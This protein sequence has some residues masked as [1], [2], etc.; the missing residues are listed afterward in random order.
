[1]ALC[2]S[3]LLILASVHT[4]YAAYWTSEPH[5]TDNF[6]GIAYG[7]GKF[8]KV[9]DS[10]IIEYSSDG[11]SWTSSSTTNTRNLLGVAHGNTSAGSYKFLVVGSGG[12]LQ[13]SVDGTG[14]WSTFNPNS[15]NYNAAVYGASEG[16]SK[17]LAVGDGGQIRA[18]TGA[19]GGSWSNK[20][21]SGV[22]ANVYGVATGPITEAGVTR[23]GFV[24][25]GASGLIMTN[26]DAQTA[27]AAWVNRTPVGVSV[28]LNNVGYF[29]NKYVAVG[30]NGTIVTSTDG[31][32]WTTLS[33]DSTGT[34]Q[35]LRAI[36][37][38]E[39]A[40]AV[41]GDNGTILT[42]T[43]AEHWTVEGNT[44]T[45]GHLRSIVYGNQKFVAVGDQGMV[46]ISATG[47][48]DLSAL[49]ISGGIPLSPEFQA[50]FYA[51]SASVVSSVYQ[52]RVKPIAVNAN[53]TIRVNGAVV[54][55]GAES[56]PIG[57]E[58]GMNT[59]T[60]DV[61]AQDPHVV[62]TYTIQV[63]RAA[64]LSDDARLSGLEISSG[65]ISPSF[66]SDQFAY[67]AT[68]NHRVTQLSVVPTAKISNSTI[69][70]NGTAVQSGSASTGL[71]LQF[72]SNA[73]N[74]EATA[75]DGI[76]KAFYEINVTRQEPGY[77]K[78][79]FEKAQTEGWYAY[80]GI[81]TI[82][83]EPGTA[84]NQVYKL[85]YNGDIS[86]A[87]S[88]Q[89][90]TYWSDYN[91]EADVKMNAPSSS[92]GLAFK[93]L[94]ENNFYYFRWN[95][96]TAKADLM[97]RVDGGWT[98]TVASSPSL[99][100][101]GS[102][103][104]KLK[105]VVS[106]TLVQGFVDGSKVVE[107]NN[108]TDQWRNWSKIGFRT[109]NEMLG[110]NI[111]VT[112][113]GST[114]AQI[115]TPTTYTVF[116]RNDMNYGTVK[117]EGFGKAASVDRVEAR[118]ILMESGS[119]PWSG[120]S[121]DWTP[122]SFTAVPGS[123]YVSFHGNIEV[124]AGGWYRLEVRGFS[125]LSQAFQTVR[126]KIG[127]GDVFLVGGQ[128]NSGNSGGTRLTP[129]DDRVSAISRLGGDAAFG[130]DPLH[131]I[132]GNMGSSWAPLGDLL[133][134]KLN[135]P[136]AFVGYGKGGTVVAQW[137]PGHADSLYPRLK[138]A[139][140]MVGR[141]GGAKAILWH[142]GETDS[143]RGTTSQQYEERL[144]QVIEESRKDAVW[145][146]NVPW[147]IAIVSYS[148]YSVSRPERME[149][150]AKGHRNT[151]AHVENTFI[152]ADTDDL[153]E[154]YRRTDEISHLNE[155]GQREHAKRWQ[156]RLTSYFYADPASA[157]LAELG[158]EPGPITPAFNSATTSYE[159]NLINSVSSVKV[160]PVVVNAKAAVKVK[161]MPVPVETGYVDL[162]LNEGVNT[163]PIQVNSADGN[164]TKTYSLHVTR[165]SADLNNVN[166]ADLS[167]TVGTLVP[168]FQS[169]VTAYSVQVSTN[170]STIS[171][172]SVAS[173]L[174]RTVTVN[175]VATASGTASQAIPLQEGSNTIT[176]A[177]SSGNGAAKLYTITVIREEASAGMLNDVLYHDGLYIA[178]GADKNTDTAKGIVRTS[179]D[180]IQW[181]TTKHD[182]VPALNTEQVLNAIAYG[183]GQYVAAAKAGTILVTSDIANTSWTAYTKESIGKT[184]GTNKHLYDLVYADGR[185]LSVGQSGTIVLLDND[186][187]FKMYNNDSKYSYGG[188][189]TNT[190]KD[191]FAVTFGN[192]LYAAVGANGTI[193]TTRDFSAFTKYD[194]A[195][196]PSTGT[197]SQLN[198]VAY[199]NGRFVAV[200][201]NG[202]VLTSPDG[203]Q[204]TA[205]HSGVT[206][207]L[208][209]VSYLEQRFVAVGED[210]VVLLS[211]DGI[212]WFKH[213]SNHSSAD[214]SSVALHGDQYL[215]VGER[216][217]TLFLAKQVVAGVDKTFLNEAILEAEG[218]LNGAVEGMS[219]GQFIPGAI[220]S[221]NLAVDGALSVNLEPEAKQDQVNAALALLQTAISKFLRM[222]ITESTGDVNGD[223]VVSVGDI[224]IA[225]ASFG[226][227]NS[228]SNWLEIKKADL[229]EDGIVDLFD[230]QF[231]SKQAMH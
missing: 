146:P 183:N 83:T 43:D 35:H 11:S 214:L 75:E 144:T 3:L 216:S 17:F 96:A 223:G 195:S 133:V 182:T 95:G 41:V 90:G 201:A 82:E 103:W 19:V 18:H 120:A 23:S 227:N 121:V 24:I 160:R 74:I 39:G 167:V 123:T 71:P 127:V 22:T 47:S 135:V 197:D 45:A 207:Q 58:A 80:G 70:V 12:T 230:I 40:F 157:D 202:L 218:L 229:N 5:G 85:K 154:G 206:V 112:P 115:I 51:Y 89:D 36:A 156:D 151:V 31:V 228:S 57:L 98:E 203:A 200:G 114:S 163:I 204:W 170:T 219:V 124:P 53:A 137:V 177:V 184:T 63:Q 175:G 72:G 136:V 118:V 61:Y 215:I 130:K 65:S 194:K 172:T 217:T 8:L 108:P 107:W 113:I 99:S 106:G 150:V 153:R 110:D 212:S 93:V 7:S 10:G 191:L 86:I 94:D 16:G 97:R 79:D 176:V 69:K 100:L 68:V 2:I 42:S 29:N 198:G 6:N 187:S 81:G 66:S 208:K 30:N 20:S 14:S 211:D 148:P 56:E 87:Y 62:Q 27:S 1:M 222:Q 179:T 78:E 171:V 77:W 141:L 205:Q 109:Q 129:S 159:L 143:D 54:P 126:E 168:S 105:V 139:I 44:G 152:G 104:H 220:E 102:Q 210:G 189:K 196:T 88:Y 73:I 33:T 34:T 224:G 55:S 9:G 225:A 145:N 15:I 180:G 26:S 48:A 116:Q 25:V 119:V 174:G 84:D 49:T 111:S 162:P 101:D 186:Q 46:V 173:D 13:L 60:V 76:T 221:F 164:H 122:I 199:G 21:P 209:H 138:E 28:P 231:I 190:T 165:A 4:S 226:A 147:G 134:Q 178:V 91:Y 37:Y 32:V 185:F 38:G 149:A 128:S 140:Q 188:V 131:G 192:G 193:V 132:N 142:Q 181:T 213:P 166:L 52:I 64:T 92:G 155:A 50:K 158:V 67:T 169:D 161:G 117:L 59:V 125:G